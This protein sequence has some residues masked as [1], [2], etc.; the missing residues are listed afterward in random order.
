ME[1]HRLFGRKPCCPAPPLAASLGSAGKALHQKPG[2]VAA[3]QSL[4]SSLPCLNR[5]TGV[6]Q[7]IRKALQPLLCCFV[8][9]LNALP[10]RVRLPD[11]VRH[12]GPWP[13]VLWGNSSQANRFSSWVCFCLA[14]HCE[15]FQAA[16][17]RQWGKKDCIISPDIIHLKKKSSCC[18]EGGMLLGMQAKAQRV[19]ASS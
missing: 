1:G 9:S 18:R 12:R 14:Q 11:L 7:S 19:C 4:E 2:R 15:A 16:A 8:S 5:C 6:H 3:I 13:H 10:T 17:L